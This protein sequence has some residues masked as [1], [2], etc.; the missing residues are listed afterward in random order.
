[1]VWK[2][3]QKPEQYLFTI[4]DEFA[5]DWKTLKDGAKKN[6]QNIS[7]S[8]RGAVNFKNETARK[9]KSSCFEPSH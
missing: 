7:E 9:K 3:G 2:K 1:M 8:L 5:D 4:T 6:G